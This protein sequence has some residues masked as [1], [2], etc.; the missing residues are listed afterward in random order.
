M[1]ISR[2][3]GSHINRMSFFYPMSP[4]EVTHS[5]RFTPRHAPARSRDES[6]V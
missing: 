2:L 4:R 1:S 5:A 3:F 6:K